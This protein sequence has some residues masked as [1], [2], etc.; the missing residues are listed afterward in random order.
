MKDYY[1]AP[2]DRVCTRCREIKH[3]R[4]FYKRTDGRWDSYCKKCR[5]IISK[6]RHQ[7]LYNAFIADQLITAEFEDMSKIGV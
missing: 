1:L 7:D 2:T 5:I 3:K 4:C 6:Q